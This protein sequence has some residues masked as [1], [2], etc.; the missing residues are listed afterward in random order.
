MASIGL[1][2]WLLML[3]LRLE[4]VTV[5]EMSMALLLLDAQQGRPSVAV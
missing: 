4:S 1:T 3:G 5:Q 2:S